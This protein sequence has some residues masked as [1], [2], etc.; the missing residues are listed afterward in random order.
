MCVICKSKGTKLCIH[1][2]GHTHSAMVSQ[3]PIL[4]HK[5]INIS[6]CIYLHT[7]VY[8]YKYIYIC[9]LSFC[10]PKKLKK[11]FCLFNCKLHTSIYWVRQRI[12]Q[13]SL[14]QWQ[15]LANLFPIFFLLM[16]NVVWIFH[17]FPFVCLLFY[18]ARVVI[19]FNQAQNL[20]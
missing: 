8:T 4:L 16:Y 2:L 10:Y 17:H 3:M 6:A 20:L 18:I 7:C 11:H 1:S 12:C 19:L 9:I 14:L 13:I 15:F 5:L